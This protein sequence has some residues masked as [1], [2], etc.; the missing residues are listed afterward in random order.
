ML[1]HDIWYEIVFEVVK[2]WF[3]K[4]IEIAWIVKSVH[5]IVVIEPMFHLFII[6]KMKTPVVRVL[7]K[8]V[9]EILIYDY[10]FETS[11]IENF[12]FAHLNV[13]LKKIDFESVVVMLLL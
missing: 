7:W 1:S 8:I 2:I 5:P 3:P 9:L 4:Y 6:L 12:N 11:E 10:Y 13:F